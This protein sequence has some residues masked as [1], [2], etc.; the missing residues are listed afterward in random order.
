M[1]LYNRSYKNPLYTAWKN[2]R[3]RCENPNHP[4]F[5]CYG[6]KG[7]TVC[8]RWQEFSNF[9]D[10]VGESWYEGASLER[11]ENDKGYTPENC[12][13]IPFNQQSINRSGRGPD[14]RPRAA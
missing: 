4:K 2:M 5:Y 11:R 8:D 9:V 3:Q 1:S 7:I 13:W 6:E 14:R 12:H 10:D